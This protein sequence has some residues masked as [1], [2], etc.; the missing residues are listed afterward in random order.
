M[1]MVGG[2]LKYLRAAALGSAMLFIASSAA[3]SM[4]PKVYLWS[5]EESGKLPLDAPIA[6]DLENSLDQPAT[7]EQ[8]LKIAEMYLADRE[9]YLGQTAPKLTKHAVVDAPDDHDNLEHPHDTFDDTQLNGVYFRAEYRKYHGSEF[10]RVVHGGN[11]GVYWLELNGDID[12]KSYEFTKLVYEQNYFAGR[13]DAQNPIFGRNMIYM[14]VN[15][16]ADSTRLGLSHTEVHLK[17][18][19]HHIYRR[20]LNPIQNL[21]NYFTTIWKGERLDPQEFQA[22]FE[23]SLKDEWNYQ[24]ENIKRQAIASWKAP[25]TKDLK[26]A[27]SVCLVQVGLVTT[28]FTTAALL[29]EN[30]SQIVDSIFATYGWLNPTAYQKLAN[31]ISSDHRM[32]SAIPNGILLFAIRYWSTF[33]DNFTMISTRRTEFVRRLPY[34]WL[35]RFSQIASTYGLNPQ[36]LVSNLAISTV[37]VLVSRQISSIWN[38]GPR[39]VFHAGLGK[40][41]VILKIKTPIAEKEISYNTGFSEFQWMDGK[42]YLRMD[43]IK[44]FTAFVKFDKALDLLT[45]GQLPKPAL[46][47]ASMAVSSL[48]YAFSIPIANF[49]N[50]VYTKKYNLPQAAHY[51]EKLLWPKMKQLFNTTLVQASTLISKHFDLLKPINLKSLKCGDLTTLKDKQDDLPSET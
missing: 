26:R 3:Y 29:L 37:F 5:V 35:T 48:L 25:T 38:Y 44:A 49:Y 4:P 23:G 40:E 11:N 14:K 7:L 50:Y 41:D 16:A 33:Y 1:G 45:G 24:S 9:Q 20:N 15:R 42:N 36:A 2:L 30:P 32:L 43:S 6:T 51:Q 31:L 19:R 10:I 47:A 34:S 8:V 13:A 28:C 27:I 39:E 46:E 22:K 17:L 12:T 21:R 18:Q